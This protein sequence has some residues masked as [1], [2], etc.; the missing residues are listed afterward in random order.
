[1]SLNDIYSQRRVCNR[2]IFLF[3]WRNKQ[4]ETCVPF[5]LL[6]M[7]IFLLSFLLPMFSI[8]PRLLYH[9]DEPCFIYFIFNLLFF[10]CLKSG[11]GLLNRSLISLLRETW[12]E[13]D[14]DWCIEISWSTT[15]VHKRQ[16]FSSFFDLIYQKDC[17]PNWISNRFSNKLPKKVK[18]KPLAFTHWTQTCSKIVSVRRY[19]HIHHPLFIRFF[20]FQFTP[21]FNYDFSLKIIVYTCVQNRQK[22]Q[23]ISFHRILVFNFFGQTQFKTKS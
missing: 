21:Y 10:C 9:S 16:H 2:N 8:P 14:W 12:I 18:T 13:I 3:L 23:K 19:T 1:M 11:S 17:N 15:N 6:Y 7:Y 4:T 5:R 22:N 20:C